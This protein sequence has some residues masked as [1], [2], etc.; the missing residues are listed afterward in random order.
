[1]KL[2]V[3]AFRLL[4]T[5][6]RAMTKIKS[7]SDVVEETEQKNGDQKSSEQKSSDQKN[8]DQKSTGSGDEKSVGSVTEGA[9]DSP[10]LNRKTTDEEMWSVLLFI[11]VLCN[12]FCLFSLINT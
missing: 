11:L 2:L 4:E 9:P 8:S 1:M 10:S 3:C 7:A 5:D 6:K 12:K